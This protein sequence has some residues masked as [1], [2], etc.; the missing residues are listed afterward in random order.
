MKRGL[1]ASFRGMD[2]FDHT[3]PRNR[4]FLVWGVKYI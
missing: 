4:Q 2:D 1:V 3:F